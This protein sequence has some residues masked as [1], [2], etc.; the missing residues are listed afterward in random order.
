MLSWHEP[1][2]LSTSDEEC[3]KVLTPAGTEKVAGGKLGQEG[4]PGTAVT[5][6][7][8]GAC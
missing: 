2:V 7:Q 6:V 3:R 1:L 5:E 8:P 4:A